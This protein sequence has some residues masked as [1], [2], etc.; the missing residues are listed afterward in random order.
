MT[1]TS[2]AVSLLFQ[3]LSRLSSLTSSPPRS[4]FR[5]RDKPSGKYLQLVLIHL[6]HKASVSAPLRT[7]LHMGKV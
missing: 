4:A 6:R 5:S 3:V 7:E 1:L 2:A